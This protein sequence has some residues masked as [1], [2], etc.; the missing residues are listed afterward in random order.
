MKTYA[1]ITILLALC[2]WAPKCQKSGTT[3]TL[4][5]EQATQVR[6]AIVTYLEC[7]ECEEGELEAVVKMGQVAVPSLV[8]T[9][10]EGPSQ[11]N[12]ELLRRNLT[13]TYRRLK[14]YEQTHP[15]AKISGSEADYVKSYTDNYIARY[16][17]RAATALGSIGGLDAKRALEEAGNKSL[18]E[19]V[20]AAIKASLEKIK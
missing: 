18:R 4:P 16:R 13:T 20:R 3:P 2:L 5:P 14:E 1:L 17:S 9:L 15:E 10:L 8:A 11:A 6:H 12:L 7:E 19:D